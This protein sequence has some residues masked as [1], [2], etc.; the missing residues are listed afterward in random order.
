MPT[1]EQ[2]LTDEKKKAKQKIEDLRKNED[3]LMQEYR[4]LSSRYNKDLAA[5]DK[6]GKDEIRGLKNA[7]SELRQ[8]E[9]KLQQK[10]RQRENE[11]KSDRKSL[12]SKLSREQRDNRTS[13]QELQAQRERYEYDLDHL[14]GRY[15][16]YINRLTDK[17]RNEVIEKPATAFDFLDHNTRYPSTH[18]G[19][20]PMHVV[21]EH[22]ERGE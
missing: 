6:Q 4:Q 10:I 1:S 9:R 11:L 20:L 5:V 17:L 16:S 21:I 19:L 14:R 3:A 2:E 15:T 22:K 12:E 18:L 7:L 13:R 8:Q